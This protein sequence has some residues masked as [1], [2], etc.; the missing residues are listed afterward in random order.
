[1]V[2]QTHIL[3]CPTPYSSTPETTLYAYYGYYI[4]CWPQWK[5]LPSYSTIS[6]ANFLVEYSHLHEQ[7]RVEIPWDGHRS[8]SI[9]SFLLELWGTNMHLYCQLHEEAGIQHRALLQPLSLLWYHA[10]YNHPT[11]RESLSAC[12]LWVIP[13]S[14]FWIKIWLYA[15][16]TGNYWL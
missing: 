1:M 9:A 4:E 2:T 13:T 16:F 14:I 8:I 7:S 6:N 3:M 15:E 11:Q 5:L 12:H 10:C